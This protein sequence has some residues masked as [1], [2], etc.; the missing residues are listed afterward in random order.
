MTL[1]NVTR[2]IYGIFGFAYVLIGV[3]SMVMPTGWLSAELTNKFMAQEM[4]S[5]S[6]A[7][8]LQEFGTVVLAVGFMF[9]HFSSRKVWNPAS[10]G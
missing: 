10:I 5:E 6:V 7:H 4:E 3:G 1:L 8:L 2:A 9:L